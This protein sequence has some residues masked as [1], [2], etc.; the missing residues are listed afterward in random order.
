MRK[1][2][3]LSHDHG[4]NVVPRVSDVL[5]HLWVLVTH[6][7]HKEKTNTSIKARVGSIRKVGHEISKS[8]VKEEKDVS[9]L[10]EQAPKVL[11]GLIVIVILF[12]ELHGLVV[13]ELRVFTLLTD[14]LVLLEVVGLK[15]A[16]DE[17]V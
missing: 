17:E 12:W 11:F 9:S 1:L 8:L 15:F 14:W 10:L 2:P 6:E 5:L 4:R 3:V 16:S 13:L 7:I